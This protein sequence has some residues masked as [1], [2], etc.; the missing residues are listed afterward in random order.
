MTLQRIWDA[1]GDETWRAYV[2]LDSQEH[3]PLAYDRGLGKGQREPGYLSSMAKAHRLVRAT[4]GQRLDLETFEAIHRATLTHTSIGSTF[5][6][7]PA[8]VGVHR[9]RMEPG[10]EAVWAAHD[11]I[12]D[13]RSDGR[14]RLRFEPHPPEVMR[15]RIEAGITRM[16]DAIGAAASREGR[17]LAIATFHQSLELWHPTRDGNTRRHALVLDKLLVEHGETPV[18]MTEIND[19]YVRL[20]A[21]WARM[22]LQGMRRWR[23]VRDAIEGGED[24]EERMHELDREGVIGRRGARWLRPNQTV[25]APGAWEHVA[26]VEDDAEG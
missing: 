1:L 5:R 19:A 18:I 3:G 20:P 21:S 22:I 17:I 13:P 23:V 4:L 7:A 14:A 11:A 16:Y 10:I 9:D 2:D 26:F 24:V 25:F 15:A 6:D 12:P 8:W